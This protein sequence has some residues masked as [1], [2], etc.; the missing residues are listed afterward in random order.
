MR[1]VRCTR[2]LSSFL[3]TDNVQAERWFTLPQ[4]ALVQI[5][6]GLMRKGT[7]VSCPHKFFSKVGG[8]I[9]AIVAECT[10]F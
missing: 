7:I 6:L 1:E 10:I 2:P 9:I 5:E 4:F 3:I 8:T